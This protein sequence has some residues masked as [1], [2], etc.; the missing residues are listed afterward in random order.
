[1]T[2][3]PE[4]GRLFLV[5]KN[6]HAD[7]Q[8]GVLYHVYLELP[9]DATEEKKT[10]YVGSL[11]FFGAVPHGEHSHD[12]PPKEGAEKFLSFD[13]TDL[14]KSL[15]TMKTLS[16]KPTMTISPVCRPAEDAKPVIGAISIV[17]Q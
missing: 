5:L 15:Q 14:A 12:H 13:V 8:P 9:A 1:V 4:G 3:L 16:A 7:A 17:E 11:N 6:L 2:G 10:Y